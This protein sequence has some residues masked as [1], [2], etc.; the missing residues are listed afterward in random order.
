[1]L[2][3][4]KEEDE[5]KRDTLC[6]FYEDTE[7]CLN[8]M[9]D[10]I[11]IPLEQNIKNYKDDIAR[12]KMTLKQKEYIVLVAGGL[13][14][15]PNHEETVRPQIGP[16]ACVFCISLVFSNVRRVLSQCSTRLRLLY[17]LK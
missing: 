4:A 14:Y 5:R 12:Y 15:S 1:M 9:D 6:K 16:A 8:R 3:D 2:T 7:A 13:T 17:L 11:R 10:K